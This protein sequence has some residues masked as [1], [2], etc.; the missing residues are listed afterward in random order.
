[1]LRKLKVDLARHATAV[2]KPSAK[3]EA[4]A[5]A[6]KR[7][8]KDATLAKAATLAETSVRVAVAQGIDNTDIKSE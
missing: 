5:T 2:T 4:S 7:V 1:M 6:A 8:A 3:P